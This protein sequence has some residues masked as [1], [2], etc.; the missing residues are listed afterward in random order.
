MY[1]S[2]RRTTFYRFTE[3]VL[4]RLTDRLVAVSDGQADELA[5]DHGIAPRDRFV[6]VRL[7]LDLRPFVDVQREEARRRVRSELGIDLQDPLIAIVGRVVPIKNHELLLR[8]LPLLRVRPTPRIIVVGDGRPE[9]VA[10][11]QSLAERVG[12]RERVLWLGWRTDMPA[13]LAASDVLAVPSHDE[14]TPVAI[15]EALATGTPVVARPVGGI[16][17]MLEDQATCRLARSGRPRDFASALAAVLEE[18]AIDEGDRDRE[19]RVAQRRYSRERMAR[20]VESIYLEEVERTFAE[21]H[22]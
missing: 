13:L 4:A 9:F 2:P 1:F 10:D 16:P 15:I 7:G 8:S 19:R 18:R 12:V 5:N 14:G 20:E 3:R 22:R 6:T 17:E 11:L 21:A